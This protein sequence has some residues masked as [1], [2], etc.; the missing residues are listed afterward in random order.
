MQMQVRQAE[1]GHGL[2]RAAQALLEL[3]WRTWQAYMA[4]SE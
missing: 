2:P 3:S 1:R 4:P